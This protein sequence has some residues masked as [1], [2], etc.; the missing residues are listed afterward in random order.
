MFADDVFKEIT[1]VVDPKTHLI[2]EC[3]RVV[4]AIVRAQCYEGSQDKNQ[5]SEVRP[6]L[7]HRKRCKV[8]TRYKDNCLSCL[9]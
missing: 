3:G 4:V 5:P 8:I 6:I 9:I 1:S 2:V 7:A